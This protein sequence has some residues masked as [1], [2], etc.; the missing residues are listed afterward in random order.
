VQGRAEKDQ[1]DAKGQTGAVGMPNLLKK[2][3]LP[4]AKYGDPDHHPDQKPS[5]EQKMPA[6]HA[7]SRAPLEP[8][9]R[10]PG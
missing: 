3:V 10:S 1:G 2:P 6:V 9:G 4:G 7:Q 5:E 8:H